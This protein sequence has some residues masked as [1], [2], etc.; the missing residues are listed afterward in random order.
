MGEKKE[1]GKAFK[2]GLSGFNEAPDDLIWA[3]INAELD[4]K[5]K[6]RGLVWI[7]FFKYFGLA[8]VLFFGVFYIIES[9]QNRVEKE[10][11]ISSDVNESE[12]VKNEIKE[13]KN[14][15]ADNTIDTK[16]VITPTNIKVDNRIKKHKKISP[17]VTEKVV[18]NKRNQPKVYSSNTV[19]NDSQ[20]P[21][22]LNENTSIKTEVII[23]VKAPFNVV[24][25]ISDSSF[26]SNGEINKN[27]ELEFIKTLDLNVDLLTISEV[28]FNAKSIEPKKK[29]AYKKWL[30][31]I[32]YGAILSNNFQ[33]K[34][35]PVFLVEQD[36]KYRA[37]NNYEVGVQYFFKES[38]SLGLGFNI[39]STHLTTID[40]PLM[41]FLFAPI[42]F[43]ASPD[44][45]PTAIPVVIKF[46]ATQKLEYI[47][48]PLSINYRLVKGRFASNLSLGLGVVF[49]TKNELVIVKD[50][51]GVSMAS[52]GKVMAISTN[53]NK[54]SLS[55][56]VKL[57]VNYEVY[58]NISIG[59]ETYFKYQMYKYKEGN[60][61]FNPYY[62][63]INARLS[64]RF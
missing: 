38:L 22:K 29:K 6:K 11:G 40:I 46:N 48:I 26:V 37:Q 23:S 21:I 51:E 15:Q 14:I 64:Y 35:S 1:I 58:K 57:G 33:K 10:V 12:L 56:N 50:E 61:T 39:F 3:K 31:H 45:P 63:G 53:L 42:E 17:F 36:Y 54:T 55:S 27:H 20:T 60:P 47:E 28:K 9:N 25:E 7:P 62:Y 5:N 59:V 49:L 18:G 43:L 2:E 13:D 8:V 44:N 4:E 16:Q 30:T 34:L 24:H 19:E 32:D 52:A 41:D